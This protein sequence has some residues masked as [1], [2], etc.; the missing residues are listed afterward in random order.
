MIASTPLSSIIIARLTLNDTL[1]L[2]DYAISMA[3]L[4]S[5]IN[6]YIGFIYAGVLYTHGSPLVTSQVYASNM[7]YL[8]VTKGI[9]ERRTFLTSPKLIKMLPDIVKKHICSDLEQ[10]LPAKYTSLCVE[11]VNR[12]DPFNL[13]AALESIQ[14]EIREL[15]MLID[16]NQLSEIDLLLNSQS[17]LNT[18]G[19]VFYSS[20]SSL[21]HTENLVK[22]LS[23]NYHSIGL[24]G[25]VWAIIWSLVCCSTWLIYHYRWLKPRERQWRQLRTSIFVLNQYIL[26]AMPGLIKT[27][28]YS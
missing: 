18:D 23:E 9:F 17:F 24:D 10:Y 13:Q 20:I 6:M 4:S 25:W 11:V 1:D 5:S 12:R 19:T 3:M 7:A 16:N 27:L 22:Y 28:D 2:L 15:T 26:S 21:Y 8:Q 14:F